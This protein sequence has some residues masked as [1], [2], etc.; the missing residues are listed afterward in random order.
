MSAA[1]LREFDVANPE[2]DAPG[3]DAILGANPFV[4][5][6]ARDVLASLGQ[7]LRNVAAHPDEFQS[8]MSGFLDD[9]MQVAAGTSEIKPDAND[10]RFADP[11]FAE[12]PFFERLM[13]SYLAWRSAMHDLAGLSTETAAGDDWKL[14][15]QERFAVTLLTE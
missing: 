9:L 11:A 7:F 4:G 13:Q 5:I 1:A 15:A 8:R 6:S 10:R 3:V 12:N 14:P 2:E